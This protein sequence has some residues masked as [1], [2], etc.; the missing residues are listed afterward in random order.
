M[1]ALVISESELQLKIMEELLSFHGFSFVKTDT[2]WSALTKADISQ[3]FDALFIDY[4]ED[5]EDNSTFQEA[6]TQLPKKSLFWLIPPKHRSKAGVIVKKTDFTGFITKPTTPTKCLEILSKL[7]F[8]VPPQSQQSSPMTTV[9]FPGLKALCVDDNLINLRVIEQFLYS[10]GCQVVS[11]TSGQEAIDL[12]KRETFGMYSAP[13][14]S[15]FKMLYSWTV[16]C[17]W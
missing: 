16:T 8:S 13:S 11:A 12:F 9:Q 3:P 15:H 4:W 14:L 7:L 6:I 2:H 17:R 10:L 1:S 5:L